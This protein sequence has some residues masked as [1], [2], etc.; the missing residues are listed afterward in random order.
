[1]KKILA[2]V[3]LFFLVGCNDSSGGSS[4]N[5]S[6]NYNDNDNPIDENENSFKEVNLGAIESTLYLNDLSVIYD[7]R[8]DIDNS[9]EMTDDINGFEMT[10]SIESATDDRVKLIDNIIAVYPFEHTT[11][12]TITVPVKAE[13]VK[14]DFWGNEE[15]IEINITYTFNLIDTPLGNESG[16]Y[17][18]T[19]K[20][21]E[22]VPVIP[23]L[24]NYKAINTNVDLDNKKVSDA[25]TIAEYN[26]NLNNCQEIKDNNAFTYHHSYVRNNALEENRQS[27][28]I[29]RCLFVNDNNNVVNDMVQTYFLPQSM[30]MSVGYATNNE[31]NVDFYNYDHSITFN[32]WNDNNSS[33]DIEDIKPVMDRDFFTHN[34]AI[35]FYSD[36]AYEFL[37]TVFSYKVADV[38]NTDLMIFSPFTENY[39]V[40]SFMNNIEIVE[41]Q[42]KTDFIIVKEETG[43]NAFSF[44]TVD[45]ELNKELIVSNVNDIEW[46]NVNGRNELMYINQSFD[47]KELIAIDIVTKNE[48][49]IIDYTD[50]LGTVY[51]WFVSGPHNFLIGTFNGTQYVVKINNDDSFELMME[52]VINH[53]LR[54][55]VRT[56]ISYYVVVKDDYDTLTIQEEVSE[57]NNKGALT[58]SQ[59][60]VAITVVMANA[61]GQEELVTFY[62]NVNEV[63]MFASLTSNS[64]SQ[65]IK[66]ELDENTDLEDIRT[67]LGNVEVSID[68]VNKTSANMYRIY[69]SVD[70][71]VDTV[72]F[73]E[74]TIDNNTNTGRFLV[75]NDFTYLTQED[76][77]SEIKGEF[78]F[79][80]N[81]EAYTSFD[82]VYHYDAFEKNWLMFEFYSK[83]NSVS[84]AEID[85]VWIRNGNNSNNESENMQVFENVLDVKALNNN[86]Y[87][88][89][90]SN[91]EKVEIKNYF[92]NCY[93]DAFNYN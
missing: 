13:A 15:V 12:E 40:V 10:Y 39:D 67:L 56:D 41:A 5:G 77:L 69:S 90:L 14:T 53:E 64:L 32:Y 27:Q 34:K 70:R 58:Y 23:D 93:S 19:V 65:S 16:L 60:E 43:F 29:N 81:Y 83:E 26:I 84:D 71:M 36:N 1:M 48:R 72:V 86:L 61:R 92:N 76:R 3:G 25:L 28:I 33:S 54:Y 66:P 18:Y 51:G 7:I 87:I 88:K 73:G 44:W 75:Y 21:L 80:N 78:N 82:D 38:K 42:N 62:D 49:T 2:I 57:R 68:F 31:V 91:V 20:Y 47:K 89:T 63:N 50:S 45:R 24:S 37:T 74:E 30:T 85:C 11:A 35:D 17:V 8:K 55:I 4:D 46:I 79:Q 9:N 6:D 22:T 52:P 59:T